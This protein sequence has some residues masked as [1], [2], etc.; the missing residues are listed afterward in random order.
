M[1]T[2][3]P[4]GTGLFSGEVEVFDASARLKYLRRMR[5]QAGIAVGYADRIAHVARL[6]MAYF[7]STVVS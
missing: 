4:R 3:Q 1:H 7:S 2:L 5:R 6:P